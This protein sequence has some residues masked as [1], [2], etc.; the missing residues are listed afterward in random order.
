[1][2]TDKGAEGIDTSIVSRLRVTTLERFADAVIDELENGVPHDG[3]D[4]PALVDTYSTEAALRRLSKVL[5]DTLG[6]A[7]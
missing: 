6:A 2:A 7:A 3:R 4:F 1:V 5:T